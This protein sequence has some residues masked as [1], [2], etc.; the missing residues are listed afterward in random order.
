M[1]L[2][3]LKSSSLMFVVVGSMHMVIC[4]RF[5]EKLAN[6]GKIT[7]FT[8]ILFF[9][10]HAQVSLNL[11][12]WDLDHRHLRSMLKISYAASPCLSQL[13]SAQF[14][15]EMCLAARNRQKI[16]TPILA[17]KVIQGHWIRWQSTA[18]VRLYVSD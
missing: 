15:L 14:A 13:I 18:S 10:P 8:W 2:I 6:N 16:K 12:N 7:T 1:M 11:E 17:F 5:H 9:D 4:N 3:R